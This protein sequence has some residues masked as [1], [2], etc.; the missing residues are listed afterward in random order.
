MAASAKRSFLMLVFLLLL[1][2]VGV[3]VYLLYKDTAGPE[4]ALAPQAERVGPSVTFTV[5]VTDPSGIKAVMVT[6][7]QGKAEEA[8][9]PPTVLLSTQYP[10]A[11]TELRETFDLSEA[12]F[13]DGEITL[14]LTATDGSFAGFGAGNTARASKAF[15]LDTTAPRL[16]VQSPVHNVR[17][18]GAGCVVFSVSEPAAKAGVVVGERFFPGYPLDPA[19]PASLWT[20]FFAFP[21]DVETNAY[22]PKLSATD[23]AGNE[24]TMAL[25]VNALPREFK[26]DVINLPD[27]FLDRKMPEFEAV[28]PGQMTPLERYL[29]VN[30][31]IRVQNRAQLYDIAATSAPAILWKGAFLR[32]KGANRAG[33]ADHRTYKYKG[34]PVDEQTHLGMDIASLRNYPVPAG[35]SG[36]V[37]YAGYIGIYGNCVVLDH[38]MGLQT[39]YA[40]LSEIGVAE[41][42]TVARG[43]TIGKTGMTGLAGGDHLHFGV[44]LHGLPVMPLEWW[45]EHWIQDNVAD[46]LPQ[47]LE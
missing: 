17:R 29:K 24:R 32:M 41:G 23:L 28:V 19:N 38:G 3:G 36:T 11:A 26:H 46:R 2:V 37:A 4:I 27:A 8:S 35:N 40:H 7:T 1:A 20:A 6:A 34:E 30:R 43:Q 18:G 9:G 47:V 45:D 13:T 31:E 42:E 5:G 15:L 14:T 10:A 16:S 44:I 12:G 22:A 25:A 39:L 21:Y 33:F